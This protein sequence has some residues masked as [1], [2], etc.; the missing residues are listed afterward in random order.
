MEAFLPFV[1][2]TER[3]EITEFFVIMND[4]SGCLPDYGTEQT[5]MS[6]LPNNYP[7]A[8]IRQFFD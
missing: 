3:T 2:A 7:D 6:V 8:S 4:Q 1:F 5:G